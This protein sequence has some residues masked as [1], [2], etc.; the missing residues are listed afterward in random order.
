MRILL[1][2]GL[3]YLGGRLTESLLGAGQ[4]HEIVLGTRGTKQPPDWASQGK[5]VAIDW[6]SDSSLAQACRNVDVVVHLAGMNAADCARDPAVALDVYRAGTSRLVHAAVSQ[7]VTRFV[8]V[9]TA[10]VY[11]AALSGNV[12][13]STKPQPRHPYATS[14]FA[15]EEVVRASRANGAIEAVVVRLSNSFGA[16]ADASANCLTLLT[17]DLCQQAVR[18]RCMVL[19]TAGTQRRDFVAMSEACRAIG[20]LLAAPVGRLGDGLFNVGS[21]TA[22][23]ILQMAQMAVDRVR[24][25]LGFAPVLQVGEAVDA[26]GNELDSFSV[27]R[28]IDSGFV[29]RPGATVEE[30]DRLVAFA[31]RTWGRPA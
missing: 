19:R 17:N 2:G 16:P 31:A 7:G 26:V 27:R 14:H 11:G 10:H 30:L 1:T 28:L 29:P 21:G 5:V 8:Y 18:D 22:L 6:A 15:A 13:E 23:T 24:A 25:V 12:D 4:R 20:H 9:S 3:G